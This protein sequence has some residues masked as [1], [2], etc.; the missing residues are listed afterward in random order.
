MKYLGMSPCK[1][2]ISDK[3]Q[4]GYFYFES[5]AKGSKCIGFLG[6]TKDDKVIDTAFGKVT[7]SDEEAIAKVKALNFDEV[8]KLKRK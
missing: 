7:V 2:K 5:E 8:P 4:V 1:V 6:K 3:W